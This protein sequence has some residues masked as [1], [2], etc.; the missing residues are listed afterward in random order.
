MSYLINKIIHKK[1]TFA[2]VV[3][4]KNQFKKKGAIFV[5]KKHEYFQLGFLKHK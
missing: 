1:V 2:I 5:T 3:R 4:K